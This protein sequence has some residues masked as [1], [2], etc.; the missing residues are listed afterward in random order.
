MSVLKRKQPPLPPPELRCH[1]D[2]GTVRT[3]QGSRVMMDEIN[4][5]QRTEK[6]KPT[7]WRTSF[8][9]RNEAEMIW[10]FFYFFFFWVFK[11]GWSCV[12][13]SENCRGEV[14]NSSDCVFQISLH[15]FAQTDPI[16]NSAWCPWTPLTCVFVCMCVCVCPFIR[17]AVFLHRMCFQKLPIRSQQASPL[18]RPRNLSVSS[19]LTQRRR[20][21]KKPVGRN[22]ATFSFFEKAE[23]GIKD[24]EPPAASVSATRQS[25]V[26]LTEPLQAVKV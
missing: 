14:V 26:R 18:P 17:D 10:F 16:S 12:R 7:G 8:Y 15:S 4:K 24:F 20:R 9:K 21:I 13:V 11:S 5:E 2:G 3:S 1:E 6:E 23:N 25:Q 19:D 22:A